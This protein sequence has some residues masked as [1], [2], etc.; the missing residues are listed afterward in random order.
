MLMDTWLPK[1][2]ICQ[3][4]VPPDCFK[5]HK[6]CRCPDFFQKNVLSNVWFDICLVRLNIVSTGQSV[7][8]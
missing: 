1:F 3:G 2:D 5:S 4:K 7:L 8:A 6:N